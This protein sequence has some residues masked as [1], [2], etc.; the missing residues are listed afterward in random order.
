MTLISFFASDLDAA[1]CTLIWVIEQIGKSHFLPFL[2]SFNFYLLP[3]PFTFAF[4]L[5]QTKVDQ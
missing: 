1:L 4:G 5:K 2:L 3:L